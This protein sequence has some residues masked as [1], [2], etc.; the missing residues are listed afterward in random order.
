MKFV[1]IS[2]CAPFLFLLMV[3]DVFE[4]LHGRTS[5]SWLTN[6]LPQFGTISSWPVIFQVMCLVVCLMTTP[7]FGPWS[8]TKSSY[9]SVWWAV[10]RLR[11]CTVYLCPSFMIEFSCSV[12]HYSWSLLQFNFRRHWVNL[13]LEPHLGPR[14]FKLFVQHAQKEAIFSLH[15]IG[16]NTQGA[17]MVYR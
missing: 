16:W 14:A 7:G 17:A 1:V 5:L 10:S 12:S 4:A 3:S 6:T 9:K 13:L 15:Q 2:P 11:Q 8:K